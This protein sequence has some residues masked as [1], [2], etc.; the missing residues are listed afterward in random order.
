MI[1]DDS[2][3]KRVWYVTQTG[4]ELRCQRRLH[5][6]LGI[7]AAAAETILH[8]RKQ[9]I[10]HQARIRQ[11]ESELET[12][13][14]RLRIHSDSYREVYFETTWFELESLK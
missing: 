8:L 3:P 13:A 1:P 14:A 9:V 5:N 11:L 12:Q 7:N 10:E 6:D 4:Y 2:T